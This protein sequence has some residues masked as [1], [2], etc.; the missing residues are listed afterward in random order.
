MRAGLSGM[1]WWRRAEPEEHLS[2]EKADT[3]ANLQE[4]AGRDRVEAGGKRAG[5]GK[6]YPAVTSYLQSAGS[7]SVQWKT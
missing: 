3:G 5:T 7:R 6:R 1:G 2:L 4:K